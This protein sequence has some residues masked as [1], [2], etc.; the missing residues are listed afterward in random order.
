M[1]HTYRWRQRGTKTP[2]EE[3]PLKRTL[4]R[5]HDRRGLIHYL[6]HPSLFH[7]KV[8]YNLQSHFFNLY[9]AEMIKTVYFHCKKTLKTMR[10]RIKMMKMKTMKTMK[11]K[12]MKKMKMAAHYKVT[13]WYNATILYLSVLFGLQKEN[14]GMNRWLGKRTFLEGISWWR[15]E[16]IWLVETFW[17]WTKRDTDWGNWSDASGTSTVQHR[18]IE[19]LCHVDQWSNQVWTAGSALNTHPEEP[20]PSL[21][22]RRDRAHEI[23]CWGTW[24]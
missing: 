23:K 7:K 8:E 24:A 10:M 12:K 4:F 3:D 9:L 20:A 22:L 2:S 16:Q 5:D 15:W 11:M 19:P 1:K 21:L 18:Q 6:I 13:C 14:T 17:P